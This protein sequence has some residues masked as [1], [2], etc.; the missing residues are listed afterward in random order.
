[1]LT[2]SVMITTKDRAEDLRRTCRVLAKLDPPPLEVLITADGCTDHTL[3]IIANELPGA[4]LIVNATGMG[5]VASRD[6]MMREARGDLV[7]A[8]DDDSYPEQA[9][10]LARLARLFTERPSLAIAT[11]PQRTDEYPASLERADFGPIRPVR[12]FPN[13]GAC[14]RVAVYRGL[15]GFEPM[16]FHMYEEP[17]YALQCIGSGWD[18]FY[19]PEVVIRH[20][21]S[22]A[23]RSELRNHHRHARNEFWSTLMR[24]PFPQALLFLAYR[25]CSQARYAASRGAGWLARE[26]LWWWQA[27]KGVPAALN[28]RRPV[29]WPGY[30]RWLRT[31]NP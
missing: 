16:F 31:P 26:P 1:M 27:L 30:L 11:F 7:L 2:V 3:D 25:V 21:Y 10:C 28:R 29:S 19:F 18:L 8:L 22:G 9:D 6:R 14:L 20:H 13:S 23:T 24:C 12:S 4:R 15:A 17:D 5:S